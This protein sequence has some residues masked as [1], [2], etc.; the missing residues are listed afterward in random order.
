M[1]VY[2]PPLTGLHPVSPPLE[3]DAICCGG[4]RGDRPPSDCPSTILHEKQQACIEAAKNGDID[5]IR[6]LADGTYSNFTDRTP[7]DV[8]ACYDDEGNSPLSWAAG[9]GYLNVCRYL[10]EECDMDPA[11]AVGK[12]K[13]RRQAIHWSARNGHSHICEWLVV[14]HGIDVDATTENGTTPLHFAIWMGQFGCVSW[15]VEV[16]KCNVNK[17]NDFGCNAAHWC[18]FKGDV[19]MLKYMQRQGLDF[20]H[21]NK[22]KR[23]AVHKAAVKGNFEAC[24]WLLTAVEEGGGGLTIHHMQPDLEGKRVIS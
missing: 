14:N 15:L 18:G 7:L 16:G 8:S 19:D 13:R 20:M 12:K 6:A 3:A 11:R 10:V 2:T 24:R 5:T 4:V 21:I 1:I 22:N 17:R 9:N 23:S